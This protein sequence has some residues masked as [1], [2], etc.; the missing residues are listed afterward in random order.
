MHGTLQ[1]NGKHDIYVEGYHPWGVSRNH[2][3]AICRGR[4][5]RAFP[6]FLLN[7]KEYRKKAFLTKKHSVIINK[8]SFSSFPSPFTQLQN[9][10]ADRLLLHTRHT[11]VGKLGKGLVLA[12]AF[13]LYGCPNSI[14]EFPK[15]GQNS[16]F[17]S[18][19]NFLAF[20]I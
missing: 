11:G 9:L 15:I 8:R 19:P 13:L 14:A 17:F 2:E 3:G 16:N 7:S 6:N 12:L 1:I 10:L 20:D 18:S 5:T 4:T